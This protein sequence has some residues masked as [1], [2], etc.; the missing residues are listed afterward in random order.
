MKPQRKYFM[1]INSS[2][3]G[4]YQ[5][6]H[7]DIEDKYGIACKV[8]YHSNSETFEITHLKKIEMQYP[9]KEKKVEILETCHENRRP[10]PKDDFKYV[11]PIRLTNNEGTNDDDFLI[12]RYSKHHKIEVKRRGFKRPSKNNIVDLKIEGDEHKIDFS[13]I[14]NLKDLD[15]AKKNSIKIIRYGNQFCRFYMNE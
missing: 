11:L 9:F 6:I 13:E 15:S 10:C 12:K 2:S 5:F 4:E 7:I 8:I 1:S 3:P 14:T